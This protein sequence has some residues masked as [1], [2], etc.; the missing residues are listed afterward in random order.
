MMMVIM[1]KLANTKAAW[2]SSEMMAAIC[3]TKEIFEEEE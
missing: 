3:R 1:R 2:Y